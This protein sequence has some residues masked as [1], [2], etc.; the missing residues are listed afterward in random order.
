MVGAVI[1]WR[2]KLSN[3]EGFVSGVSIKGKHILATKDLGSARIY[4]NSQ[5]ASGMITR[6]K[7][8][9]IDE[10]NEYTVEKVGCVSTNYK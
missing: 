10:Q 1:K 8:E 9:G 3:E 5:V 6:M 7:N 4:P 2:N